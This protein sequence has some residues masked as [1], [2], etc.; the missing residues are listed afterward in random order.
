MSNNSRM[1]ESQC[2]VHKKYF[3]NLEKILILVKTKCSSINK[4]NIMYYLLCINTYVKYIE[5]MIPYTKEDEL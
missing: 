4:L 5:H 1:N 2:E 3:Y